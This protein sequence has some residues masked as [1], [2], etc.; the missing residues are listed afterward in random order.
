MRTIVIAT[1][2]PGK[3]AELRALLAGLEI[4]VLGLADLSSRFD[5]PA[6]HGRTFEQN[7][8]IKALAYAA[9]TGLA[10]LADDS[11]LEVDALAG[12]PGVDSAYYAY[13]GEAEARQHPRNVRDPKNIERVLG[14]LEGVPLEK[15]S[16]RFVCCMALAQHDA[17]LATSR[18]CFE[19]R[20]GIPP[21]VPAG[22]HGFGYD[23][24]FLVAPDFQYT[25]AELAPEEKNAISHRAHAARAIVDKV[26]A[27]I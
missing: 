25:S 12:R 23:P 1:Q 9:M 3:V 13:P 22:T 18:G 4:E 5:E 21:R 7:A 8:A 11:G 15:R 17:V 20:I 19:G 16:A 27:L 6:E 26:R 10:C 14:E 24:I 2:N